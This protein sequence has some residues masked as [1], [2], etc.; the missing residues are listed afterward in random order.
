MTTTPRSQDRRRVM[1]SAASSIAM[2]LCFALCA[3]ILV[4]VSWSEGESV[5]MSLRLAVGPTAAPVTSGTVWLLHYG[6][7]R[8]DSVRLAEIGTEPIRIALTPQRRDSM[9]PPKLHTEGCVAAI[10]LPGPTWYRT[11]D[12]SRADLIRDFKTVFWALGEKV[13]DES[14]P[15]TLLLR[16][17]PLRVL[18]LLDLEG[19]PV[20]GKEVEVSV[21]LTDK[22]HCGHHHGLRVGT[23][24][25]DDLGEVSLHAPLV[26]LYL[27]RVRYFEDEGSGPWGRRFSGCEGLRLGPDPVVTLQRA[28][29]LPSLDVSVQVWDS[30]G[31]PVREILLGHCLRASE[32]GCN[33]GTLWQ[34]DQHGV[35]RASLRPGDTEQIWLSRVSRGAEK[36]RPLTDDEIRRLFD[37]GSLTIRLSEED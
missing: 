16:D 10:E 35:I 4:G 28:W 8:L 27:D 1:H 37:E 19:N 14:G 11:A 32:C 2:L 17:H 31:E 36:D 29:D 24:R 5:D 13:E 22:N 9:I 18:R 12:V 15:P 34:T 30:A 7:G 3:S 20:G 23:F 26:D 21:Y 6:W 33:C 25:T